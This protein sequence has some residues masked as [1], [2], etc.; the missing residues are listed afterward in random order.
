MNPF[1]LRDDVLPF[2]VDIAHTHDASIVMAV[3]GETKINVAFNAFLCFLSCIILDICGSCVLFVALG[4]YRHLLNKRDCVL[5]KGFLARSGMPSLL[6][7]A[8][9]PNV[10]ADQVS[11]QGADH[12]SAKAK[13]NTASNKNK[14]KWGKY[15]WVKPR[16]TT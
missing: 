11:Y 7:H 6:P 15:L 12:T 16:Q 5:T 13:Q 9:D 10:S 1:T 2:L 8:V 3:V 14:R 4:I